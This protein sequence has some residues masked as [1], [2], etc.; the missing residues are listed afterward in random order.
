ML[1]LDPDLLHILPSNFC[2]SWFQSWL[3]PNLCSKISRVTY[4]FLLLILSELWKH[5]FSSLF[6][7]KSHFHAIISILCS[8][9]NVIFFTLF[10]FLWRN[11]H[12]CL[13]K[14]V[15][16]NTRKNTLCLIY[17]LKTHPCCLLWIIT[18][19][20]SSGCGEALFWN[21]ENHSFIFGP[22]GYIIN[23]RIKTFWNTISSPGFFCAPGD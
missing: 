3:E 21:Y 20:I 9:T 11:D 8:E 17:F 7:L 18:P 23:L 12:R 10:H 16:K 19:S 13:L 5:T 2:N 1:I 6:Q 14:N 15:C 22:C 4:D